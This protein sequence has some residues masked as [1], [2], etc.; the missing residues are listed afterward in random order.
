MGFGVPLRHWFRDELSELLRDTLMS[1]RALQR[2]YFKPA[3]VEKL[4][5]EHMEGTR[6]NQSRLWTLLML[7]LWHQVHIDVP[8]TARQQTSLS[9]A[10]L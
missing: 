3:A 1:R 7:E 10:A 9:A 6:D 2:G 4:I 5:K 8:M